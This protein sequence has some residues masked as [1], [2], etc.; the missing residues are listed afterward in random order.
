MGPS[1]NPSV[2]T[3]GS[4]GFVR[5]LARTWSRL[6]EFAGTRRAALVCFAAALVAF[7]IQSIAWPLAGGRDGTTYLMYYLDMWHSRPAYPELMLFRTPLAPLVFGPLLQFGGATLAEVAMAFA[8][9]AS[10]LAFAV[11]ALGFGRRCALLTAAALF[12]YPGYGALFH[13]VSSDSVFALVFALWTLGVA[14][15]MLAPATWK[16]AALGVCVVLLVLARPSSQGLL[17]FALAPLLLSAP[18]RT[19]LTWSAAYL[20]VALALVAG[21]ALYND[22]RYGDFTVA[23]AGS[24]SVPFYRVFRMEHI[25]RPANG[26]ASRSLARAVQRDLLTLPQY[27]EQNVSLEQFFS[28]AGDNEW[29]DLVVLS[30]RDWGWGSN[31]SILRRVALEAIAK[32]P[33]LYAQDI[34]DSTRFALDKPYSWHVASR[35]VQRA[36]ASQPSNAPSTGPELGGVLW[37]LAS[38][39]DG[40]ITS[41][42][43][44]LVWSNPQDQ[45]HADWLLRAAN[46]LQSDLPNRDGSGALSRALNRLSSFYPRM[47]LWLAVGVVA[48]AIRRPNGKRALLVIVGLPLALLVGTLLGLPPALEYRVPFDPAFVLFGLAALTGVRPRPSRR[49]PEQ[50]RPAA[51][52]S[53]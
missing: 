18:W 44:R 47:V 40:H 13:Q 9:A 35:A 22:R 21:Y 34:V 38:T 4:P 24:A 39:P 28:Q 11:A 2:A 15:A 36:T 42:A 17:V 50:E 8:Y 12:L 51:S 33:K 6:E 1:A 45:A 29:G 16:F 3:P 27:R 41:Q 48:L 32:H 53:V 10:I 49:W 52:V 43:G 19:R 30:D 5:R 25:V 26:P 7:G 23:R 46:R 20:G 37:W 31:Y 14:R